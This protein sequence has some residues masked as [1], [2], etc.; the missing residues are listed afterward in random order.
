MLKP[1]SFLVGVLAGAGAMYFLDP[2]R[3]R[4][5]RSLIRDQMVHGAHELE[6]FGGATASRV[7]DLGNRARG[8]IHEARARLHTEMADDPILEA[9]VRTELGRLSSNPAWIEVSADHGR[10]VLTGQVLPHE[11]NRVAE[12]ITRVRGVQEL[13]NR[14]KT[15]TGPARSTGP[16]GTTR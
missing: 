16:Q 8:V 9:R 14:L 10:V 3:G 5:R 2:D 7:R 12:G 15:S 11:L 13:V 4:R 6:E 1:G